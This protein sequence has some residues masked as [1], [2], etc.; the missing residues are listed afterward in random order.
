MIS[1]IRLLGACPVDNQ[2]S[3]FEVRVGSRGG[4][5][6]LTPERILLY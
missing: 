2:L 5:R 3:D 4:R 6:G 1:N